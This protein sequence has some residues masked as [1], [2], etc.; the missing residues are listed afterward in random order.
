MSK[1]K[2][3][4]FPSE[5]D[6]TSIAGASGSSNAIPP[7]N[8]TLKQIQHLI[9][10][11]IEA[12]NEQWRRSEDSLSLLWQFFDLTESVKHAGGDDVEKW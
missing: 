12:T 1:T 11:I 9:V 7:A 5:V 10:A 2:K 8:G 3:Y 4:F 6:G